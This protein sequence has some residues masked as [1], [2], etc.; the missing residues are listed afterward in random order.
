M[1]ILVGRIGSPYQ[2]DLVFSP[3]EAGWYYQVYD[4]RRQPGKMEVARSKLFAA[5]SKCE[6]AARK[7]MAALEVSS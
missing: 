4:M 3:D 6:A 2:A 5:Q 7:R 1:G